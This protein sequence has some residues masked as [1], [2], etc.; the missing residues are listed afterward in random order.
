MNSEGAISLLKKE[1]NGDYYFRPSSRGMDH[2]SLTWKFYETNIVHLD[3]TEYE[4]CTKTNQWIHSTRDNLGTRLKISDE[5]YENLQEIIERYIT[6]C[7]RSLREVT[8][9]PKFFKCKKEEEVK[10]ELEKEKKEASSRIPYKFV[11]LD[12]YPQYVILYYIPSKAL[13]IEFIKI[14]P[15]GYFFHGRYH[16]P[17]HDLINWFKSEFRSKESQ[18]YVR[19]TAIPQKCRE[20][21]ARN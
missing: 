3:I 20:L 15:R 14:K 4:K 6:P 18:S 12:E 17:F 9:H 11:I 1:D 16:Y 2:L 21:T 19:R 13:K 7:N 8:Q 5:F 10:D